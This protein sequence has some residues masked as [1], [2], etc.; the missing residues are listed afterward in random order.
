MDNSLTYRQ[1]ELL[2]VRTNVL[3]TD[4]QF[5]GPNIYLKKNQGG[6]GQMPSTQKTTIYTNGKWE[7]DIYRLQIEFL[8][9]IF[10][11]KFFMPV[12]AILS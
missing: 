7:F 6:W 2:S 8:L 3:I 12:Q 9:F 1:F 10:Y 5:F 11:N 4:L